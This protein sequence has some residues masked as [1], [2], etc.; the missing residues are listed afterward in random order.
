MNG[1]HVALNRQIVWVQN[2]TS[3]VLLFK[4]V[5]TVMST[6]GGEMSAM[7]TQ[8]ADRYVSLLGGRALGD[9]K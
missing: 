9:G 1:P 8:R 5:I 4:K 7:R 6:V 3:V 2:Y